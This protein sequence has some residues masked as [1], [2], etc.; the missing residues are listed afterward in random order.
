MLCETSE[1]L[2]F[3]IEFLHYQIEDIV[4]FAVNLILHFVCGQF[5][6]ESL[7]SIVYF[8]LLG[9]VVYFVYFVFILFNSRL[10]QDLVE[11]LLTL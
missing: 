1:I 7:A 2:P 6:K 10:D 9:Q 3:Q 8:D 5:L 4:G 11:N